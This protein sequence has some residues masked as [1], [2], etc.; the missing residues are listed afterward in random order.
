MKC[1]FCP[2]H[3]IHWNSGGGGGEEELSRSLVFRYSVK[4]FSDGYILRS[5]RILWILWSGLMN[6]MVHYT[7]FI[8]WM[9]AVCPV[10]VSK[11]SIFEEQ[12]KAVPCE[13]FNIFRACFLFSQSR[14]EVLPSLFQRLPTQQCEGP[15]QLLG[16]KFAPDFF[17]SFLLKLK[18]ILFSPELLGDVCV[19]SLSFS[20]EHTCLLFLA[21]LLKPAAS[22]KTCDLNQTHWN[23]SPVFWSPGGVAPVA[24]PFHCKGWA[25]NERNSLF[26]W[27]PWP[28]AEL[29]NKGGG[30][31][32][33][34][35]LEI[36][37]LL[38]YRTLYRYLLQMVP[39]GLLLLFF[40]L[41]LSHLVSVKVTWLNL[42]L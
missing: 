35:L 28:L 24:M 23:L 25:A 42:A 22:C 15:K 32:A 5:E 36:R 7:N 33:G 37:V 39:A 18:C 3:Y 4:L 34:N 9:L 17:A 30:Q 26:S 21:V 38:W 31:I 20:L 8:K 41:M 40:F 1:G 11:L 13:D 16:L 6:N 10:A 2:L 27:S 29:A 19:H 14:R 12:G